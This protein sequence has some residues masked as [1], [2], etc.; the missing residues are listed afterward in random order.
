MED[1]SLRSTRFRCHWGRYRVIPLRKLQSHWLSREILTHQ[2][3][4]LVS[5]RKSHGGFL[6]ADQVAHRPRDGDLRQ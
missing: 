4:L 3:A 2:H 5:Q 1:S 6:P